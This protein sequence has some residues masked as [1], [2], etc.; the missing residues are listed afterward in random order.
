QARVN[1]P[2]DDNGDSGPLALSKGTL[3]LANLTEASARALDAARTWVH[4][5]GG[6]DVQPVH[7]L[8]GLI[9]EEEG[10][11]A[12][13]LTRA[14]LLPDAVGTALAAFPARP[15]TSTRDAPVPLHP[16]T[17]AVLDQ[18]R[19]LAG[20]LSANRTVATEHLLLA[21]LRGDDTLR[22]KLEALGLA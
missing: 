1:Y 14:G 22:H 9:E 17:Q 6:R 3:M 16:V 18:A 10:R 15:D 4:R 11:A 13:L 12:E 8:L 2:K 20:E 19:Q 21:L 7:L 5:L